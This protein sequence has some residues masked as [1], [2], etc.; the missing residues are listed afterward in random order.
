[1]TALCLI[2]RDIGTFTAEDVAHLAAR[3]E[4]DDYINPFEALQ[5]WHL[6]WALAFQ[7]QELVQP[8]IYLLEIESYEK[9]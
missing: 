1:M 3:L 6:L 2:N 5:D 4:Q 8:Y 7:R 9:A